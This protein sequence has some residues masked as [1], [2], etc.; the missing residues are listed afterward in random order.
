MHH[1]DQLPSP[2]S[3]I[4]ITSSP[5]P[6]LNPVTP[7]PR[8]DNALVPHTQLPSMPTTMPIDTP[9]EPSPFEQLLASS[10]LPPTGP[11]HFAARRALWWS[12]PLNKENPSVTTISPRLQAF[13]DQEGAIENER[14]WKS[15]F[16]G[17][18]KGIMSGGH[19]KKPIPLR[20]AVR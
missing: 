15:G 2:P 6:E 3:T 5:S 1:D 7:D 4:I 14:L 18:W 16:E 11:A 20:L 10:H 13:L 17:L 12:S 8:L 19:M 9:P